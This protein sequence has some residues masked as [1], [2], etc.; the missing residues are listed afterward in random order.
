MQ[1]LTKEQA[2]ILTGFTGISMVDEFAIFHEDVEKRLNRPVLTHE[3]P[4][5]ADEIKQL[6]SD[7]FKKLVYFSEDK[8]EAILDKPIAELWLSG[9]KKNKLKGNGIKTIGDL[10]KLSEADLKFMPNIGDATIQEIKEMLKI[11]NLELGMKF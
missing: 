11:H 10:V 2:I 3:I 5:L 8:V 9:G 1:R 4:T 7:D 6:Y